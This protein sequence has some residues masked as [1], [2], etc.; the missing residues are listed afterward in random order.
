MLLPVRL[1]PT[2]VSCPSCLAAGYAM[3]GTDLAYG[4]ARTRLAST[5]SRLA[6]PPINPQGICLYALSYA[7]LGTDQACGTTRA[8]ESRA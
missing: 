5:K 3:S 1:P 8:E 4:A 7:M 2:L 6:V